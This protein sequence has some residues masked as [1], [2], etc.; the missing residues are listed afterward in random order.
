MLGL[1]PS[2]PQRGPAHQNRRPPREMRVFELDNGVGVGG[3]SPALRDPPSNWAAYG[4][5]GLKGSENSGIPCFEGANQK[6]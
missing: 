2:A 4:N 6:L 1:A 3:M 5:A